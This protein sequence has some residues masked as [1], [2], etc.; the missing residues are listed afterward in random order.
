MGEDSAT[1]VLSFRPGPLQPVAGR[2]GRA[3]RGEGQPPD[4]LGAGSEKPSHGRPLAL[5]LPPSVPPR[6]PRRGLP[7]SLR[8]A[9]PE[10]ALVAASPCPSR[11]RSPPPPRDPAAPQ[12]P[13]T[14]RR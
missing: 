7:C 8:C 12:R 3:Q 14:P 13:V 1:R 2:K 5:M 10:A 4:G 11:A 6:A 9:L